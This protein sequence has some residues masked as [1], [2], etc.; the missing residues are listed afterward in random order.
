MLC[1]IVK[2]PDEGCVSHTKREGENRTVL[3]LKQFAEVLFTGLTLKKKFK[4]FRTKNHTLINYYMASS[5]NGQYESNPALR[6]ATRAGKKYG[7]LTKCEV[8]LAI[9]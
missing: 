6:L 8:K 3:Q 2:L 1:C 9:H 7:L 5:M 4:I